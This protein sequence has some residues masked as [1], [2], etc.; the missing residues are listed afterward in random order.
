MAPIP[1]PQLGQID[2]FR[3]LSG[4][5]L[6]ALAAV[7]N[8]ASFA[9]GE[10]ILREGEESR[11]LWILLEGAAQVELSVPNAGERQIAELHAPSI[12]GE[13]SFFHAG[14]HSATV[15]SAGP[16]RVLR[17]DRARFDELVNQHSPAA[18]R[19]S[20]KAAE[21]LAARLRQTNRW[22][23]QMLERQTDAKV[24]QAWQSFR[25]HMGHHFSTP[26][27]FVGIGANWE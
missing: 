2:L 14:P 13:T 27:T 22:I 12:F 5:E 6:A 18:L 9:D 1:V 25:Q 26:A 10:V 8:Q 16:T 23:E 17:L 20:L 7:C 21:I 4:D 11:A 24:H 15:T 3:G 19:V